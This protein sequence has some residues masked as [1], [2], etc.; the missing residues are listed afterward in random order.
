MDPERDRL[1]Y[2]LRGADAAFFEIDESS[3]RLQTK[4]WLN[5]EARA[6]YDLTVWTTDTS[7]FTDTI[8]VTIEI[9]NLD[10]A[11]SLSFSADGVAIE[12]ALDDRDGGVTGEVWQWARSSRR[13]G[14]W[15]DISGASSA[16]YT[17]SNADAGMYLQ[18]R[19]SYEDAHGS[20][21]RTQ[22]VSS[23]ELPTPD[24]RVATL[25]S[26]LSIPWDLAFTPDGTML[27]T[28]RAGVLSSRLADGTVQTVTADL[29]DLY[30]P[31]ETGF[32]AIV[33]DP[34]F[35]SNRRFYTCQGHTGPEVQVIAWTI[36]ASYTVATRVA[37][38]L[39]GGLPT[40]STSTAA[41]G[42]ASGR[43]ATCGSRRAT[44]EPARSRRT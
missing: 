36:D 8:D 39:V 25:V 15:A 38:P 7:G 30:A 13:N 9:I 14:G 35:R 16:R 44:G 32:M 4:D 11:G 33:I 10:E 40:A 21:K 6:A 2:T 28:Q 12:A 5:Y 19:V 24:I 31:S 42:S 17:P 43:R 37:D 20:G 22:G 41:A 1:T 27:F 34:N 23:N 29:S 26:G 3:G 18:A